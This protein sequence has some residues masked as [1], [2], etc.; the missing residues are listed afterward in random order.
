VDKD[1]H[2]WS[3]SEQPP[4][5]TDTHGQ[6]ISAGQD[7]SPR[8][9]GG[10]PGESVAGSGLIDTAAAE[11]SAQEAPVAEPEKQPITELLY[12]VI[13]K[14][15]ETLRYVAE[16]KPIWAAILIYIAVAW[17]GAIASIPGSLNS[18]EQIPTMG[19][20]PPLFNPRSILIFTVAGA[21]VFSLITLFITAG[22]LHLVALLLKGEG[23]YPGL[24]STVGFASFPMI[25]A[26]PFGLLDFV[27]G[28]GT[29]IYSLISLPFTLWTVVLT[30][31]G[32]RENYRFST[33]RAIWTFVIPILVVFLLVALLVVGLVALFVSALSGQ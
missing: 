2:G 23:D 7:K 13:V 17:I 14:P 9:P 22:I 26:T 28:F 1:G 29:S 12:G 32:I 8:G 30:V 27:T 31:I 18:F 4:S 6:E 16:H 10:E 25:I 20:L 21:P 33:A 15:V 24:V 11:P 3:N 19:A 5:D